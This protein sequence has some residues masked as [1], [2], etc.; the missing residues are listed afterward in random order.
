MPA[1]FPVTIKPAAGLVLTIIGTPVASI[2][3]GQFALST[4]D[5]TLDGDKGE[6]IV[7]ELHPTG[8][9]VETKRVLL[10]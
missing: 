10:T 9:A 5:I 8:Y 3:A 2:V 7:V 6:Y 1:N 4:T